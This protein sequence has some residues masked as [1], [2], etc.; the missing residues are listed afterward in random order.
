[1]RIYRRE[2]DQRLENERRK[3]YLHKPRRE[4]VLARAGL[5]REGLLESSETG[6]LERCGSASS[7][8]RK[9]KKGKKEKK[10]GARGR[11]TND[12]AACQEAQRDDEPDD[13]PARRTTAV[14]SGEDARVGFVDLAGDEI[15]VLS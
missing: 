14:T 3:R 2:A 6:L 12:N 8:R 11:E 10:K 1:V 5:L 9:G 7:R 4:E 15:V 13:A